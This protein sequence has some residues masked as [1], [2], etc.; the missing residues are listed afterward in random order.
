[1]E[2]KYKLIGQLFDLRKKEV[3][4]GLSYEEEYKV[5]ALSNEIDKAFSKRKAL[6]TKENQLTSEMIM[7]LIRRPHIVEKI[8]KQTLFEK[9]RKKEPV[10]YYE[11]VLDK[12]EDLA[13]QYYS[14]AF[15]R[16]VQKFMDGIGLGKE[17][18]TIATPTFEIE[19]G[20]EFGFTKEE[21]KWLQQ[22]PAPEESLQKLNQVKDIEEKARM[23]SPE[24][25]DFIQ[26][27]KKYLE[28][29]Y[30]IYID[31]TDLKYI[32]IR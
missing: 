18:L 8:M 29:G 14:Y 20:Y 2:D 9:I 4:E 15:L 26:S 17:W 13:Y 19:G 7:V 6:N 31:Y 3:L 22:L 21:K 11:L 23:H 5:S 12:D 1:M 30:V 25:S 24:M 28:E 10:I 16:S 32:E 27:V